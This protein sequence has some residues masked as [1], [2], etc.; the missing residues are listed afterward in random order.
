[1]GQADNDIHE[2]E[3]QDGGAL[4]VGELLRQERLALGYS[5]RDI[6]GVIN[7]RVA[8]LEAI[9]KGD[10][11]ALPGMAYATG[12]VRSYAQHL[13]LDGE[14]VV[15]A[16]KAENAATPERPEL[17]FPVPVD[18]SRAPNPLIVI[19]ATLCAVG[20]VVAWVLMSG[21]DEKNTPVA[22]PEVPQDVK[23]SMVDTTRA[24][25]AAMVEAGR[26]LQSEAAAEQGEP[27]PGAA[28]PDTAAQPQTQQNPPQPQAAPQQ[29][30]PEQAATQQQPETRPEQQQQ[31]QQQQQMRSRVALRA[32]S[33]SWV[34]ITNAS[35]RVVLK[36]VMRPGEVYRVPYIKGLKLDT[37]NA[38][39][40]E[41][42]VDN[43]RVQ[44]LGKQGDIIR[45][46]PLDPAELSKHRFY[47]QR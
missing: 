23:Q 24:E 28:M 35:G 6:S 11:D 21:G 40:L 3:M 2:N 7:V 43:K 12:F 25:I 45:N 39:A 14:A 37:A 13:G 22:V 41:V 16:F 1:M 36:K 8:Q 17:N 20:V 34:Q 26:K 27:A 30:A 44:P 47:P 46:I 15:E 4:P 9:E 38:G 19:I 32:K 10:V 29:A 18:E 33:A 5:L 31:Q 42:F